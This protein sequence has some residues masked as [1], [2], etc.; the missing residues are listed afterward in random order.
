MTYY[1]FLGVCIAFLLGLG[2]IGW[3]SYRMF[4]PLRRAAEREQSDVVRPM[5]RGTGK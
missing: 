1:V 3:A 4:W 5:V 2:L